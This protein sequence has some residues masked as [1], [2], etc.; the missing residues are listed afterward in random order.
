ML[1]GEERE[2]ERESSCPGLLAPSSTFLSHSTFFDDNR[3]FATRR[4]YLFFR[5]LTLW[6][7]LSARVSL[8]VLIRDE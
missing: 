6:L 2:R 4:V 7:L 3:L 8:I 1:A 5:P